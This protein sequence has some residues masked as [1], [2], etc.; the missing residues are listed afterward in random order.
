MEH[1]VYQFTFNIIISL[2]GWTSTLLEDPI[3]SIIISKLC[4]QNEKLMVQYS[5]NINNDMTWKVYVFGHA[6]EMP[7]FLEMVYLNKVTDTQILIR[8]SQSINLCQGNHDAKFMT[9]RNRK[10]DSS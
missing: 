5:I 6:T 8:K 7:A 9:Y 3:R 1:V 10:M 4:I 2:K